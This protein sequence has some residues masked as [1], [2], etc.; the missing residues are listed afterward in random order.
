V[1]CPATT[2]DGRLI[3]VGQHY[4]FMVRHLTQKLGRIELGNILLVAVELEL[5]FHL[6][7]DRFQIGMARNRMSL[8]H[9]S[10]I[11]SMILSQYSPRT[12]PAGPATDAAYERHPIAVGRARH[13][14]CPR[15]SPSY[16]TDRPDTGRHRR[17]GSLTEQL[18]SVDTGEAPPVIQHQK[19]DGS[20]D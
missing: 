15:H 17:R 4:I 10:R 5:L 1:R 3:G 7:Q 8:H 14:S 16:G 12:R 13:R 6:R 18:G 2:L 9:R 19:T 11:R 20:L